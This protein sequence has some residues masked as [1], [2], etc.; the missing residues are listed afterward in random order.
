MTVGVPRD[1]HAH[2][3]W[4]AALDDLERVLQRQ[5]A[6]LEHG[7]HDGTVADDLLFVSPAISSP[8]PAELRSRAAG[9]LEAT[10]ALIDRVRRRSN[11]LQPREHV[12]HPRP[13]GRPALSHFDHRA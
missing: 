11:E 2:E 6:A 10:T 7:L 9:L 3:R 13:Q 5:V 12:R 1:Q 4:S 8:L